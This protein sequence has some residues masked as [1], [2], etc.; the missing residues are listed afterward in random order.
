M[1]PC[2]RA[3][4]ARVRQGYTRAMPTPERPE[5]DTR[6]IELRIG[7]HGEGR[8]ID[9]YLP[10]A[11]ARLSRSQVKAML[12]SGAV[13]VDGK[14]VKPSHKLKV[15]QTVAVELEEEVKPPLVADDV[16]LTVV[17]EDDELLAISKP[18]GMP[19]L[20]KHRFE[21]GSLVNALV[22]HLG[23]PGDVGPR[24][25]HRLDVDTT[26]VVLVAKT[27]RAAQVIGR[28]FNTRTIVKEYRALV[29]GHPPREDDLFT[30][31]IGPDPDF[32]GKRGVKM[33]AGRDV[34]GARPASTRIKRLRR[35][36]DDAGA[37]FAWL[38]LWPKTGRTHQ[39]RVHAAAL[40][41][42]LV[43]DDFYGPPPP[44]GCTLTRHALH[45]ACITFRHP[46]SGEPCTIDAPVPDDLATELARLREATT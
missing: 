17:F 9:A 11:I 24:V 22:A 20:P 16:P 37:P 43:G 4:R 38:A 2:S 28:Q 21:G 8:R 27:D 34:E 42:P 29:H 36:V 5:T 46:A 19:T 7:P 6:R 40:G 30:L 3:D 14:R 44:A 1:G 35:Y 25:M 33:K 18:P 10:Q 15:G 13:L 32:D 41:T 31:P 26:G 39:L 45:A 12:G 23:L